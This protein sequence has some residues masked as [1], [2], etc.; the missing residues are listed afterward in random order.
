MLLGGPLRD[1]DRFDT[2]QGGCHNVIG[3]TSKP[4]ERASEGA[5]RPSQGVGNLGGVKKQMGKAQKYL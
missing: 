2:I 3:R 5:G 1:D 4:A